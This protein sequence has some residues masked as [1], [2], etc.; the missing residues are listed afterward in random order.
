LTRHCAELREEAFEKRIDR[1]RPVFELDLE[2]LIPSLSQLQCFSSGR[3][4]R[5]S[6]KLVAQKF[7]DGSIAQVIN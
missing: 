3:R 5:H 4:I 7:V 2:L 6:S 1:R